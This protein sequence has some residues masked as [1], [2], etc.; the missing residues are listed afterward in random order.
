MGNVE[1]VKESKRGNSMKQTVY[2]CWDEFKK[3]METCH[4]HMDWE[5]FQ[6][7][8]FKLISTRIQS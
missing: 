7:L 8:V 4:E 1:T 2:H 3:L 5:K 6:I